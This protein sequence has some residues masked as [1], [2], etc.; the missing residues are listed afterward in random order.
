[1]KLP[2]TTVPP[3][4]PAA[5]RNVIAVTST[6]KDDRLPAFANRGPHVAVAAPGVDLILLAPNDSLQKMS[7][8][9]FSA[10]YV[11]GTVALMLERKPGLSPDAARE[12]LM[13][14]AR[15]LGANPVDEQSGGGLVDAYQAI[16]AVGPA[17]ASET[18][19]TPAATRQ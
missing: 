7:G 17:E 13:K 6:D 9:S 1:M 15:R 12:A 16:L 5:D 11:T 3:L 4:F 8:T 2:F 14:S 10:A 18:I 19:A